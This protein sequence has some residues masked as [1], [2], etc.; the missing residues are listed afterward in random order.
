[1]PQQDLF[2][3]LGNLAYAVA[4]AD[5]KLQKEE[6]QVFSGLL[7][8]QTHGDIAL[9]ALR[10]KNKLNWLPEEAYHFAFRRFA[11]NIQDF[12][13]WQKKQFFHILHQVA[14]ASQGISK[15]ERALLRRIQVDL[16][17]LSSFSSGSLLP[18]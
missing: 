8:D 18:G 9:F 5:G 11:A 1:M 14:Q 3:G 15:A 6:E 2:I 13:S 7:L 17:R 12:S 4:K 10:L 16:G